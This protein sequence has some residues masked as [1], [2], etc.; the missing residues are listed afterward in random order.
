MHL[1]LQVY[2]ITGPVEIFVNKFK[3]DKWALD[4]HVSTWAPIYTEAT[5]AASPV[6]IKPGFSLTEA[7]ECLLQLVAQRGCCP[8]VTCVL[9]GDI[10]C[11][12]AHKITLHDS[13]LFGA[14][15]QLYGFLLPYGFKSVRLQ[16]TLKEKPT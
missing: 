11:S 1:L 10:R 14:S 3:N 2:Q 7:E 15:W 16:M 5:R 9:E 8:P 12:S 4:G 13:W 6:A